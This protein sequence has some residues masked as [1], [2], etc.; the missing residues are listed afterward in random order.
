MLVPYRRDRRLPTGSRTG[1]TT[2]A[3]SSPTPR[4]TTDRLEE[5]VGLARAI[6]LDVRASDLV[7]LQQPRPSTLL[8][9]GK[10]EEIGRLIA[11]HEAGLAIIDHALSPIQQRNLEKAW[12][13][14]VLDRTGLILEIFGERALTREGRLQVELAHLTY[15]KSRL[16]RSWTHLE[17]QR[18]GF[19]FLGGPGEAQIETDRRLI[20][21]RIEAIRRDLAGVV[22]TRA[23][24][25]AGR[26]RVPYPIVAIV[27]Y[28][29]AGKSTLFNR[30]TGA[31]V[32][33]RDQVFETL[34][35]TMREVKLDS[36]R[37]IIISDTVGFISDLPTTLVA[38]FRATLE[39]V[40]AADLVLHVRDISH[41]E[42][43]AQRR[44]VEAILGDLGI[45]LADAEGPVLEV[46][47]KADRLDAAQRSEAD[48]ALARAVRPPV[49]LSA[50]TGE[51]MAS[52]MAAIDARF[53]GRDE[54]ISLEVPPRAGR[55]LSWIHDN[56][57]VLAKEAAES[58]AVTV[59]FRIDPTLRGKLEGELKRAGLSANEV[60]VLSL[61]KDKPRMPSR[62]PTSSARGR[63]K[64]PAEVPAH[65]NLSREAPPH[66]NLRPEPVEGRADQGREAPQRVKLR[67]RPRR[68]SG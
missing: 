10:V 44:D 32:T 7:P 63:S 21:E 58:G 56:A 29:N 53:G 17:R 55:I 11:E 66:A 64:P 18:G 12:G 51:G 68:A 3:A 14:K 60:R 48:R 38:A 9:S 8:G 54:V 31:S 25:R 41:P 34:D 6:S 61:S 50:L 65:S 16:V 28:T 27:G 62:A 49:L 67:M 42:T 45:D 2:G 57:D 30:L 35:P 26:R 5:A 13:C 22:R 59:R 52:L 37:R 39:E 20:E 19:G 47:N 33:A 46:W 43:E 24:H 15:Q 36:G 23:L 40:V 1:N 4:S